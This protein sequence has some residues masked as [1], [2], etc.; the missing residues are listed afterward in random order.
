MANSGTHYER[1][2]QAVLQ[3][4]QVPYV[5]VDQAKKALFGPVQLKS[6]DFI[7]YPPPRPQALGRC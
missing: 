2:F 6:F 7:I 5:A 4:R 3:R 1:A